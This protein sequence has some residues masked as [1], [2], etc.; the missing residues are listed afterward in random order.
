MA[1]QI[2]V[3]ENGIIVPDASEIKGAFQGVFTNALGTDLNLDDS[4]PQGVMID[5][6]T[7]EKQLDNAQ[8]LY[9]MN[10]MNP[11]TASGVF[12]DAIGTLYNIQRKP[13]TASIANCICT[14]IAGT[15][16][17]G[18]NT[19]NP[20]TA[21]SVNGD[22]FQ[23]VN[24]VTIP[25]SGQT[26]EIPFV[27]TETGEKPVGA[28]TV[29]SIYQKVIG[30]DAVNNPNGGTIGSEVESRE[31]FEERRKQSLALNA[32]GSLS[33][34]KAALLNVDGVTDVFVYENDGDT[35]ISNYRGVTTI[36][37]HSIYTC[38]Q[39]G[40][41][42]DIGEAIYSSKSAG[43][44]TNGSST[45]TYYNSDVDITFTYNYTIPSAVPMY[46]QV[47]L[48]SSVSNGTKEQ[49]MNAL[50]EDFYGNA[51]NSNLKVSIGDTMY[52]SRFNAVILNMGLSGLL[53][54]SVKVSKDGTNWYDTVELNINELPTLT[55]S[56]TYIK[57]VVS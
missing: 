37:P 28:N 14:G 35:A 17:N 47:N 27:C 38:I 33:A 9:F 55:A 53:L 32:T 25:A 4:T 39:G 57:F 15:V 40:T 42:N 22:I 2:E 48:G 54:E 46:I 21:Q 8:I 31:A 18:I 44:D 3:N 49:I 23:C 16:L 1:G 56:E 26:A 43:C 30:W 19:G 13:A 50:V 41:A 11:D 12:Q 6:L 29:N 24:T 7:T 52:A 51:N 5:D 34:V 20:A 10:Q 45:A 36:K